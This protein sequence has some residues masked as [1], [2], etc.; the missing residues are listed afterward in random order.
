MSKYHAKKHRLDGYVFDSTAELKRY[1][2]LCLMKKAG[3]IHLLEIHPRF[4]L[5]PAIKRGKVKLREVKYT[6]DFAYT[7]T[8][9][10]RRIVEDVKGMKTAEFKLRLKVFLRQHPD[11][12]IRL[13][14]KY[15]RIIEEYEP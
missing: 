6:A 11:V 1:C 15:G 13:V 10:G 7:E 8:K 5:Y 12:H 2:D 14:D 9:T 3:E 4:L